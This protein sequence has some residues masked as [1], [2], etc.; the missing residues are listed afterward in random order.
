M[1]R[2]EITERE[3][4][5]LIGILDRYL[6]DLR[7]EIADTDSSQYKEGLRHERDE[8]VDMIER[9]RNAELQA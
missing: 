9:V 1:V 2:I 5:L 8:I 6:A 4:E 3:H 7:Y